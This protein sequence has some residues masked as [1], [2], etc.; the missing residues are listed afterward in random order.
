MNKKNLQEIKV[1]IGQ[2]VVEKLGLPDG[3]FEDKDEI[4]FGTSSGF[5]STQL[6]EFILQLEEEFD[7]IIPDE[8]LIPAN[9]ET[10]HSVAEY[11]FKMQ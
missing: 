7:I 11:I 4:M 1:M 6:L 5:D 9:F 3:Y 8:D 10:L 2:M